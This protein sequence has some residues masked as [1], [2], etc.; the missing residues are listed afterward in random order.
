MCWL[1][2]AAKV[3]V[4]LGLI[5]RMGDLAGTKRE[6]ESNTGLDDSRGSYV[7]DLS[8]KSC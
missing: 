2:G 3:I 1:K 4:A 7:N 5:L 6:C 8:A